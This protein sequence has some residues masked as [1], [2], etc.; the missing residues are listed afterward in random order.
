MPYSESLYH[1]VKKQLILREVA[2]VEKKMFGGVA[3]MLQDKMCI[4]VVKEQ[5]MLRVLEE[6]YERLIHKEGFELM[7]FTGKVMK[8]F[9]FVNQEY[10]NHNNN[11]WQEI[12]DLAIDF[13]E[14]GQLK[15][16]KRK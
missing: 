13:A 9:L 5:I 14:K 6:A 1:Q 2:F 4:G 12:I 3:F 15:S 8:G 16:K 10:V 7:D 11:R